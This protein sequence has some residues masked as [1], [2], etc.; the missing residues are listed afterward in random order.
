MSDNEAMSSF[1]FLIK[2]LV[3]PV[4]IPAAEQSKVEKP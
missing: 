4:I 3:A 2:F 1:C